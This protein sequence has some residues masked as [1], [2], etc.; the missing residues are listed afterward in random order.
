MKKILFFTVF[1]T[2]GFC[3]C[4]NE[5]KEQTDKEKSELQE[6]ID[7]TETEDTTENYKYNIK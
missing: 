5:P 4:K 1:L 3:S 2:I 6:K 7:S